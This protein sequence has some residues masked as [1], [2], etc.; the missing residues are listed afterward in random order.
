MKQAK[1]VFMPQ[2]L[3][4]FM[5]HNALGFPSVDFYVCPSVKHTLLVGYLLK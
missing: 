4:K 3:K 2:T 5:M 1:F